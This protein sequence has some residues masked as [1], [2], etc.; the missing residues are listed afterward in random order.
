MAEPEL[1]PEPPANAYALVGESP[2]QVLLVRDDAA[3]ET[4]IANDPEVELEETARWYRVD[5]EAVGPYTWADITEPGAQV[6]INGLSDVYKPEVI[7]RLYTQAE[8]DAAVAVASTEQAGGHAIAVATGR[9]LCHGTRFSGPELERLRQREE[10]G[11][12]A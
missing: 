8:L 11:D 1:I 2:V 10:A 3:T 9:C 7:Q 6:W 4:A 5:D 12:G